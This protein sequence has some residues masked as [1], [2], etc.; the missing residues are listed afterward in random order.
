MRGT[1]GA[2]AAPYIRGDEKHRTTT[3]SNKMNGGDKNGKRD[4]NVELDEQGST[5]KLLRG[6]LGRVLGLSRFRS[7]LIVRPGRPERDAS[8]IVAFPPIRSTN[9]KTASPLGL[10]RKSVV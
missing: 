1:G 4:R 7:R 6:R 2:R 9:W 3:C 8:D 10:D 5:G